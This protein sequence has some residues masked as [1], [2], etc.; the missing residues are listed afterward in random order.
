MNRLFSIILALVFSLCACDKKENE[1]PPSVETVSLEL[2]TITTAK[3]IGVV[4]EAGNLPVS[5]H[6]FVYASFAYPTVES[7]TIISLGKILGQGQVTAN[8]PVYDSRVYVRMFLTNSKGTAYGKL[9]EVSVPSPSISNISPTS[10]KVGD[11]IQ[12]FGNNFSSSTSDNIVKFG[13]VSAKVIQAE[14][15]MLTVEV[16]ECSSFKVSIFVSIGSKTEWKYDVF[17]LI[18]VVFDYTPKNGCFG[19]EITITGSGFTDQYYDGMVLFGDIGM[20]YT[21][22]DSKTIKVEVPSEIATTTVPMTFVAKKYN[23]EM[24]LF[25]MDPLIID[26]FSPDVGM[27]G[28]TTITVHGKNFNNWYNILKVGDIEIPAT[29]GYEYTGTITR[30]IPYPFAPGSYDIQM[31]NGIEWT[32]STK[33]LEIVNP[34]VTSVSPTTGTIGSEITLTGNFFNYFKG[35]WSYINFENSDDVYLTDVE[36]DYISASPL[37]QITVN[38]PDIAPGTYSLIFSVDCGYYDPSVEITAEQQFTVVAP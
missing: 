25:T 4:N 21:C 29:Y 12:I 26:D 15:G 10:G 1:I 2:T 16:P 34:V 11:L 18:P 35:T 17:T 7:G 20:Y 5:D 19:T 36:V 33:K 22:M 24:G 9:M 13:D 3:V 32:K 31:F 28:L 14:S 6:G 27:S 37:Q 23:Y 38:V 30:R 8:I